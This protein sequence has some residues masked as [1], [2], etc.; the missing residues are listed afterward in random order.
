MLLCSVAFAEKARYDNYRVYHVAIEN[1]VQL[2]ALIELSEVSD[3]VSCKSEKDMVH[4]CNN[5]LPTQ[6]NFW[7]APTATGTTVDLVVPPHQFAH[8]G[9]IVEKFNFNAALYINNLQE[10][11]INK[12]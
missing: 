7:E 3:S 2:K 8:F 12:F 1:D 9:E 5:F 10:Y 11:F 6:Y 4:S